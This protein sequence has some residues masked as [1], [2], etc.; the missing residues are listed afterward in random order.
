M[1]GP[2]LLGVFGPVRDQSYDERS[3]PKLARHVRI[4]SSTRSRT[5]PSLDRVG[6][7]AFQ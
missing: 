3:W 4:A 5:P 2:Y 7:Q 6:W 1:K